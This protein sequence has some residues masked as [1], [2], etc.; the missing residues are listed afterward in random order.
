MYIP[1]STFSSCDKLTNIYV[2]GP[3]N[4]EYHSEE[5]WGASG[6]TIHYNYS[7]DIPSNPDECLKIEWQGY[8][9]PTIT[10]D[11]GY[12]ATLDD[13]DWDDYAEHLI[14]KNEFNSIIYV[15]GLNIWINDVDNGSYEL[16]ETRDGGTDDSGF[17]HYT[18]YKYKI[19]INSIPAVLY[20]TGAD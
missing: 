8:H 20:G 15:E 13:P 4:G 6:A 11:L 18:W 9:M 19:T 2:Y 17:V 16:I 1:N 3:Y 10:T 5:P 12:S 14:N 7:P